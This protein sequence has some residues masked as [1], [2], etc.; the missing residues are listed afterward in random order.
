MSNYKA[1]LTL[2]LLA[3]TFFFPTII[4]FFIGAINYTGLFKT[5][6]DL[7]DYVRYEGG[8]TQNIKEYVEGLK[9]YGYD[10]TFTDSKTGQV[11]NSVPPIGT[12]IEI[13]FTYRYTDLKKEKILN[14]GNN[15]L[16]L[17]RTP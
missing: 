3:V 11:I 14:T 4:N 6:I 16:I 8:V 10:I 13:D 2:L 12:N 1:T 7:A 9:D 5:S 17:K 15:V